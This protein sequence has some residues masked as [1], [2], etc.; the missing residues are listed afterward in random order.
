MGKTFNG[1]D[2]ILPFANA[3]V[4]LAAPVGTEI[5]IGDFVCYKNDNTIIPFDVIEAGVNDTAGAIAA[6][7]AGVAIQTHTS[8][9]ST[10]GYPSFPALLG[11]SFYGITVNTEVIYNANCDSATYSFGTLVQGV[12]GDPKKVEVAT[13]PENAIGFVIAD[14]SA[15][16]T[17]K[18]RIRLISGKYSPYSNRELTLPAA[19]SI[20][21]NMIASGA[22]T[23]NL[24]ASGA[25]IAG[26]IANGAVTSGKIA[27][28]AIGSVHISSGGVASF[29]IAS[30]SITANHIA[31]GAVINADIEDN[32]VTSGKIAPYTIG[33]IHISNGGILS[34]NIASGQIS[35]NHLSSGAA[36]GNLATASIGNSLLANNSILSGN[37]ASGQISNNHLSS[38]AAISNL[39]AA[40]IGNSLLANNSVTSGNIASGQVSN[41]HLS[42]GAAIGNI[43][44]GTITNIMLANNSVTS[45]D[46]ASGAI[47]KFHI[48]SGQVV[49][50]LTQGTNV[51]ITADAN[52][53][54]T[55]NATGGGGGTSDVSLMNQFRLSVTS[56][57]AVDNSVTSGASTIYLN[58]YIGNRIAL[59][60]GGVWGNCYSSGN[61]SIAT[62]SLAS[63]N[64]YDIFC[65]NNAGVPALEYSAAYVGGISS[66]GLTGPNVRT[67]AISYL[68]GIPVKNSD[69]TRRLIGTVL[70]F[71][72]GQTSMTNETKGIANYDNQIEMNL[73]NY[74]SNTNTFNNTSGAIHY[75]VYNNL[76]NCHVRWVSC[77]SGM[78]SH[79]DG[80][81]SNMSR[82]P[83][84]NGTHAAVSYYGTG[85]T[86]RSGQ[87]TGPNQTGAFNYAWLPA[88]LTPNNTT[89]DPSQNKAVGKTF[90]NN[91]LGYNTCYPITYCTA[92]GTFGCNSILTC[93]TVNG[94]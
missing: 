34:G 27:S 41:N 85:I 77:T 4:V 50:G 74:V 76:F 46:I 63:G 30:G 24:I 65:Y 67:D 19:G 89:N 40:S 6:S 87:V 22:I 90:I 44:S 78:T 82:Q 94:L 68:N 39:A 1:N 91:V 73:I 47:G 53:V 52:D 61:V 51:T 12:V 75:Q 64:V 29:N 16:P 3:G 5:S 45:G 54:Y 23:A 10:G 31:S 58:P 35:N 14:Y 9:N 8:W 81:P 26:D 48:A 92:S 57:V 84:S 11:D 15:A 56:G 33:A 88:S 28:G 72:S 32:A 93:A 38:G 79:V 18:I 60:S 86:L 2:I 71:T 7:F 83:S 70:G 37:I 42:S 59:F 21:T 80:Q 66:G 69:N 36:I 49:K 13:G 25:I 62:S 43:L 55:I 20:T 17:T